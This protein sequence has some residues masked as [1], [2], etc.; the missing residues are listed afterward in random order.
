MAK[1]LGSA[2][3][4]AVDAAVALLHP[5]RVPGHVEVEQIPAVVL[6]VHPLAGRIGGDQDAQW[7]QLRRAVEAALEGFPFLIAD[8]A[9]EGGDALTLP[10][11]AGD[12]RFNLL[13]QPA[14][15][16]G[17]LGEDQQ[18]LAVPLGPLLP[19]IRAEVLL[20]PAAQVVD[21]GIGLVPRTLANALHVLEQ[22]PLLGPRPQFG[23]GHGQPMLLLGFPLHA[24]FVGLG[25]LV[26]AV[27]ALLQQLQLLRVAGRA[28][29]LA[30]IPPPQ[31]VAMHAQSAVERLDRA[32]QPFL[33]VRDHQQLGGA[34]L[35]AGALEPLFPLAAVGLEKAGERKLR[36]GGIQAFQHHGHHLALG[37]FLA[38][39]AQVFLETPHQHGLEVGLVAHGHPAAEAGGVKDF[40]QRREAV[41][42]AVVGR[43]GE[44]QLVL[45]A[46][47]QSA[48]GPGELGVNGNLGAAGRGCVMGLI[49]NQQG[50]FAI[51]EPI[52]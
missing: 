45:E 9:V 42:V 43:G 39:A 17:V 37:Q 10:V 29:A 27:D 14:L 32:E 8:A 50:P 47:G 4:G 15:G 20:D 35:A 31:R 5:P 23:G 52:A 30:G 24:V 36:C 7:V 21:P 18:P 22:R 1:H 33:Q 11:A 2:L 46:Q 25:T 40:Q 6:Q 12:Q 16:V 51:P 34:L 44:E 41:A 38:D 49:E 3:Q 48:D 13:L 28:Q 19:Q 26:V